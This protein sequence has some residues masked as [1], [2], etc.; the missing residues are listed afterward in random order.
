VKDVFEELF[1]N[2]C[3][4][5]IDMVQKISGNSEKFQRVFVHFKYWSAAPRNQQVRQRLIDGHQIKI[6]YDDPWFWK[7]S[8]SRIPKPKDKVNHPF[9]N[10]V[11]E[12]Y[13][14]I[15]R[16]GKKWDRMD[17]ETTR[18]QGMMLFDS[19]Q[20]L[21][22][23]TGDPKIGDATGEDA[24]GEDAIGEDAIGEDATGEDDNISGMGWRQVNKKMR[25][26]KNKRGT[27]RSGRSLR[28]A[29]TYADFSE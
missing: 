25:G 11:S 20:D 3:I 14:S 10:E 18:Q 9:V 16:K 28:E 15:G 1:G 22:E 5:R 24:T 17:R 8:A 26:K 2:G 12:N 27:N 19:P 21:G 13:N 4:E 6:V 23:M 7:C 29:T